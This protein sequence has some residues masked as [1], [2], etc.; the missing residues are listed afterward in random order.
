MPKANFCFLAA[1][2]SISFLAAPQF[3]F[4]DESATSN[5]S[6]LE[7]KYFQH[8]FPKEEEGERIERLE[9][10]VFGE[11]RSG[12]NQERLQALLDLVP[13]LNSPKPEARP[14]PTDQPPP[15]P[16]HESRPQQSYQPS[17]P[18]KDEEE[19]IVNDSSYPAVTAIE[20]K[21]LG[22]DYI[23]EN[24][25]KR[26]DRLEIKAFGKTAASKDLQER[27]DRL[28]S[29]TGV[30]VAKVKPANSE[31]A[32][33]EDDGGG[34][35]PF[36][37]ITG[38][39]GAGGRNYR[40]Q[41]AGNPYNGRPSYDPY[42]G[43]G[44]SYGSGGTYGSGSYGSSSQ[45]GNYGS[46]TYG[47]GSQAGMPPSAPD[48]KASSQDSLQGMGVS[49]KLAILEKEL[50]NRSFDKDKQETILSRLSR[51]EQNV[52]PQDK[53]QP[54]KSL[55]QRID[56][57]IAA[58]PISQQMPEPAPQRKYK[59]PEFPDL[60]FPGPGPLTRQQ[61]Q[62]RGPGGLSKIINGLGNALGGGYTGAYPV[63]PGN[64]VTDPSTGLLYDQYTGTLIDPMTG[65]V[66]GRR[67]VSN[68]GYP[69]YGGFNNG[70]SPMTPFGGMGS[71][72]GSGLNF[73]FG[74]SGIRFGG[75]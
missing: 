13:D 11:A 50:F 32:D 5:L 55:P 60:D 15:A 68:Y 74:G 71:G 23:G 43:S 33:E 65:A 38:D 4:A 47:S 28:R 19:P 40:K 48:Y 75:F 39:N 56:R 59:D 14:E 1:A 37:G 58:V 18:P 22:R 63:A 64:L 25:S 29:S 10:L 49:Q 35:Q 3:S 61:Q 6:K 72:M 36:T 42:Q 41:Q 46:G 21:V 45:A 53:P 69:S 16:Q 44:G 26:L 70:L 27:V 52:F 7:D 34:L 17:S 73:G 66:V 12:S 8:A 24:I 51:L 2:L 9:K 20:K 67:T 54:G 31:W 62:S 57:L 30:D